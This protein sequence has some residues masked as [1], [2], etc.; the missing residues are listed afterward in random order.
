MAE[1]SITL[2]NYNFKTMTCIL[3]INLIHAKIWQNHTKQQTNVKIYT[4]LCWQIR[5]DIIRYSA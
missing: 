4:L 1:K 5:L 2:E 3:Q